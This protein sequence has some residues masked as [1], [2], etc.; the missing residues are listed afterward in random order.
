[1]GK[2]D[3]AFK[4]RIH[5]S[6]F[7]PIL[8]L[9]KTV[10]IWRN[11]L[12]RVKAQFNKET[13]DFDIDR[14]DIIKFSKSHFR[15]LKSEDKTPWNGRQIRNAWQTAIAIAEFEASERSQPYNQLQLKSSQFE[16]VAKTADEF[17]DY[18]KRVWGGK[19]ESEVA[20][21]EQARNDEIM[22]EQRGQA[23]MLRPTF[24]S[25]GKRARKNTIGKRETAGEDMYGQQNQVGKAISRRPTATASTDNKA[26]GD[27]DDNYDDDDDDDDGE[28]GETEDEAEED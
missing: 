22:D 21:V 20:R 18:L 4:S 24:V 12:R 13:R 10:A 15:R 7:Y 14:E 8:D 27:D 16:K 25:T 26:D 9:K 23:R 17:D 28:D 1:M 5:L 3:P 2:I 6:L 19:D 11:H